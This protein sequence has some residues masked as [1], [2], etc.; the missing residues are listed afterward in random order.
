[1]TILAIAIKITLFFAVL[2]IPALFMQFS[3]AICEE[4]KPGFGAAMLASWIAG[5]FSAVLG[6]TYKWTLGW[7]L[8]TFLSP[9]VATAGAI[10]LTLFITTTAFSAFMRIGMG[11]AFK[12]AAVYHGFAIAVAVV[13]SWLGLPLGGLF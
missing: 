10:G 13:G 6:F 3:A 1:M 9:L 7:A 5:A 4:D 11:R 8:A 12:V 2:A